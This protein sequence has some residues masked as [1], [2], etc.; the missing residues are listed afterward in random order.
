MTRFPFG[1]FGLMLIF[2]HRMLSAMVWGDCVEKK[3]IGK[4]LSAMKE[5]KSCGAHDGATVPHSEESCCE[6]RCFICR[7]G[8]WVEKAGE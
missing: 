5:K 8:E 1:A 3:S 4:E 2:R 6:G 7:D